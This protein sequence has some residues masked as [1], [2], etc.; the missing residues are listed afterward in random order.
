[1]FIEKKR[2]GSQ[3][4]RM[5][6]MEHY[7]TDTKNGKVQPEIIENALTTL[8]EILKLQSF[9]VVYTLQV[10]AA[11][12]V[13]WINEINKL[14]DSRANGDIFCR[15]DFWQFNNSNEQITFQS[16]KTELGHYCYILKNKKK[17]REKGDGLFN[18]SSASYLDEFIVRQKAPMKCFQISDLNKIRQNKQILVT[19]L[20]HYHSLSVTRVDKEDNRAVIGLLL[21]N[22]QFPYRQVD[23]LEKDAN[24]TKD[25][26]NLRSFFASSD[27]QFALVGNFQFAYKPGAKKHH[28]ETQLICISAQGG[29]L[30]ADLL[31]PIEIHDIYQLDVFPCASKDQKRVF[32]PYLM[33]GIGGTAAGPESY[34]NELLCEIWQYDVTTNKISKTQDRFKFQDII[35]ADTF[36]SS[37]FKAQGWKDPELPMR[38]SKGSIKQQHNYDE[39][40][41]VYFDI[42]D[43]WQT[44]TKF[45]YVFDWTINDAGK[46]V[47]FD[48]AV[49]QD[50]RAIG[51]QRI[52][53]PN[54]RSIV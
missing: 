28:W 2:F 30:K 33:R 44:S 41:F 48:E 8:N 23:Y 13:P 32:L 21:N 46:F 47:T 31:E 11:S 49:I 19:Q 37:M 45:P 54:H 17:M 16:T 42:V 3:W 34:T 29:K 6:F 1:M 5:A 26:F 51:V 27:N 39:H 25:S 15:Q 36:Y 9:D 50:C 38:I 35:K 24:F 43:D 14:R 22:K 4:I 7:K 12:F 20:T 52:S 40:H 10:Q 53:N 18:P